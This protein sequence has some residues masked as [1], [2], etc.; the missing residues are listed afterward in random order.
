M[1]FMGCYRVLYI[2]FNL[3]ALK[4]RYCLE[5]IGDFIRKKIKFSEKEDFILK[6]E[7]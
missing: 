2:K 7:P 4:R 1:R 5:K 3:R 6:L